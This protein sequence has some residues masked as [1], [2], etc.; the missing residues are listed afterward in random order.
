MRVQPVNQGLPPE[1]H[2]LPSKKSKKTSNRKSNAYKH[3]IPS[4]NELLDFLEKAGKPLKIKEILSEFDLR[5]QRMSS[6]LVDQL[7]KMLR[8]GQ[9]IE[10]RRG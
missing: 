2:R 1:Q 7:H 10:N 5:G 9:I 6:L 3:Q 4:R 8:A